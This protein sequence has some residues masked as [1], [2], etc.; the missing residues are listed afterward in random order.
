MHKHTGRPLAYG[1]VLGRPTT[2][3]PV[4]NRAPTRLFCTVL[5]QDHLV[6]DGVHNGGILSLLR[7]VVS[8]GQGARGPRRWC[9]LEGC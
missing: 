9:L 5:V 3:S 4:G 6:A 8:P 2:R 7:G 1:T